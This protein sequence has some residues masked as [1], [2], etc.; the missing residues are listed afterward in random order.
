MLGI[1]G[2]LYWRAFT[3][4]RQLVESK[5]TLSALAHHDA[6]TGLPNRVLLEDR[7]AQALAR[8]ARGAHALAL[9]MLDL[10]AFKPINDRYGH[11]TGDRVLQE[12]ALRIQ[13]AV[14]EVDT[15]ARFGGD[16]FM[17]LINGFGD[18]ATLE[19]VMRRVIATVSKELLS[20]PHCQVSASIGV[21][22]LGADAHDAATL[23]RH[24]DEAMYQVKAAGGNGFRRYP[25]PVAGPDAG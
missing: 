13:K 17:L 2:V 1:L 5:G 21:S 14:R 23:M 20:C 24:A 9:C 18:Q 22:V 11:A 3:L 4:N 10:D 8:A 16:E 6:L 25:V 12:V 15:V 7:L 19:E